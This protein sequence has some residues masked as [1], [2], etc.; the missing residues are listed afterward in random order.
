MAKTVTQQTKAENVATSNQAVTVGCKLPHG[1]VLEVG[2]TSVTLNGANSSNIIGGYGLT[3][4]VDKA[5][6]DAWMEKNEHLPF[7]RNQLV[8][9]Q[10]S[11]DDAKASALE[12]AGEK[13]GFEGMSDADMPAGV[14][15]AD[16][17]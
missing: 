9:A 13:T 12:K 3:E 16:E 11:A 7:V 5:F 2:S 15:K 10:A 4:G 1:L 14:S 6:F 17:K 8:F